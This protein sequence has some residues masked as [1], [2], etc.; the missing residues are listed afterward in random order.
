[1]TLYHVTWEI[2][3]EADSPVEAAQTARKWLLDPG[4]ECVVFGVKE[5]DTPDDAVFV[6]LLEDE[7]EQND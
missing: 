5:F 4:A 3:I 2:D 7:D 6:D 1:M